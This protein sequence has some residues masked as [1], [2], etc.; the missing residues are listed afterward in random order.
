MHSSIHHLAPPPP[1]PSSSIANAGV[2]SA[3][4]QRHRHHLLP[5]AALLLSLSRPA[6]PKVL[7]R[8]S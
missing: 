3:Y 4:Q 5:L 8:V 7:E 2:T 6:S 1:C